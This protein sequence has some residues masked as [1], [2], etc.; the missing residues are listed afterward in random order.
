MAEQRKSFFQNVK[1]T[2]QKPIRETDSTSFGSGGGRKAT[3]D[4]IAKTE[5]C[6]WLASSKKPSSSSQ[7]GSA[8][9]PARLSQKMECVHLDG[10]VIPGIRKRPNY[11]NRL[12]ALIRT[13][14]WPRQ[15]QLDPEPLPI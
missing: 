3:S 8:A 13:R 4:G 2:V 12:R 11:D 1:K 14:C 7:A 10:K 15:S 9:V 5:R 6:K